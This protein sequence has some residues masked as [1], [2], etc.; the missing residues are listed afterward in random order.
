MK[1]VNSATDSY[2][3][4]KTLGV[5]TQSLARAP[6]RV[7]FVVRGPGRT[8]FSPTVFIVF[9]FLFTISFGNPLEI[10]ENW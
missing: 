3:I 8:S 4:S 9:P 7:R 2:W 6:A 5:F 10:V 1:H